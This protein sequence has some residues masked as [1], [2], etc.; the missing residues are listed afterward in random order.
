MFPLNFPKPNA[1][2]HSMQLGRDGGGEGD[3]CST[4]PTAMQHTSDRSSRCSKGGDVAREGG[5]RRVNAEV[6]RVTG[7]DDSP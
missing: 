7:T 6:A 5:K 1:Y 3:G 2:A 4:L